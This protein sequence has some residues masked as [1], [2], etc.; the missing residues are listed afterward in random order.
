[1]RS[2]T[3]ILSTDQSG[4]TSVYFVSGMQNAAEC[5]RTSTEGCYIFIPEMS[6]AFYLDGLWVW[7]MRVSFDGLLC[8]L[9]EKCHFS[10]THRS[11]LLLTES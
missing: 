1:M 11:Q 4:S 2:C 10:Q 7:L 6:V 8:F 3:D 9:Y 5:I